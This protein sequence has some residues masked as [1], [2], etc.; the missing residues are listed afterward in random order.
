MPRFFP[1][2]AFGW[3]FY[4]ILLGFLAYSSYTDLRWVKIPKALT[5]AMLG[6]GLTLN[7]VRGLWLGSIREE[8]GVWHLPPG[9]GWGAVDG[10]LFA[11]AGFAASFA[12]FLLLYVLGVA[13]GGD[14]KLFAALG[15][16]VGPTYFFLIFLLTG[17]FV[18]LGAVVRLVGKFT[19]RGAQRTFFDV[20]KGGNNVKKGRAGG[21]TP[22]L[23]E[24]Q[25]T[26][27]LAV[28]LSTALLVPWFFAVDLK[29]VA[30]RSNADNVQ[31]NA[32]P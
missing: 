17:V 16:W 6:V 1:D 2:P 15:A 10:L 30:P 14:V 29:L 13:G 8:A 19:R 9:A 7:V 23:R 26:Y 32:Q 3:S 12:F 31:A 20:G 27:S 11:L 25:M 24:N 22:K 21:A 18:F 28:A 5:L 4:A